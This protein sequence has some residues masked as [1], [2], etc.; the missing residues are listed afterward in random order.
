MKYYLLRQTSCFARPI[1][2]IKYYLA[3]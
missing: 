1:A 3:C 2:D